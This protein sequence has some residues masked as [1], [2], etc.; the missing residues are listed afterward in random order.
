VQI[1]SFFIDRSTINVKAGS[2]IIL[3]AQG[4][5]GLVLTNS[6]VIRKTDETEPGCGTPIDPQKFPRADIIAVLVTE[7][8]TT[9]VP[10][11][12]AELASEADED[13][14][15]LDL[16]LLHITQTLNIPE[17]GEGPST[18]PPN[19]QDLKR[20][21][22]EHH[23]QIEPLLGPPPEKLES[24]LPILLLGTSEGLEVGD[25]TRVRGYPTDPTLKTLATLMVSEGSIAHLP[26]QQD[27]FVYSRAFIA[28]GISGG[29]IV[30]AA[31]NFLIGVVCGK[32]PPEQDP[33]GRTLTK[34]VPID[35]VKAWLNP[36]ARGIALPPQARIAFRQEDQLQEP[37]VFPQG[38]TIILDASDSSDPNPQG[39]IT[40]YQW[41]VDGQPVVDTASTTTIRFDAPGPH[42]VTLTVTNTA[43]ISSSTTRTV[44]ILPTGAFSTE[45]LQKRLDGA[46]EGAEILIPPGIYLGSLQVTKPLTLKA[47]PGS[48]TLFGDGQLPAIAITDATGA[49][50]DGLTVT[51]GHPGLQIAESSNI[52]IQ[53][54]LIAGN[55]GFGVKITRSSAVTITASKVTNTVPDLRGKLGEGITLEDS[56]QVLI[57]QN[58]I[59]GNLGGGLVSRNSG[60]TLRE[61]IIRANENY[62][63]LIESTPSA[64]EVQ[65]EGNTIE[66]NVGRGLI[67]RGSWV[68]M[69]RD[70]VRATKRQREEFGEGVVVESD[71]N[72]SP[73]PVLSSV[74]IAGNKGAGVLVLE[75]AQVEIRNNSEISRNDDGLVFLDRAGGSLSNSTVCNNVEAGLDVRDSA[76][77]TL[78]NN[79]VSGNWDGLQVRSS[80]TVTLTNSTVSNGWHGLEVWDSAT[81]TL[82]N[83]TVSGNEDDGLRVW[84]SATVTLQD[85]SVS[86]NRWDGLEVWD[87]ATVTLT[88]STVSDN[89]HDGLE[90]GSSATV[91]LENSSISNNW[92]DGFAVSNSATVS[93]TNSTVS[94]NWYDGLSVEDSA[95]VSLTNSSVSNNGDDGLDVWD[96]ATVE[97][98]ESIMSDNKR[99]GIGV[100]SPEAQV[101]STPN[102]MR[103][104]GADLC[105][106]AP[107]S[108]RKPLVPQ[109]PRPHLAVP[110]DY[111]SVQQAIDA[112]APG[113]TIELAPGIYEAGL[114][115]WKPLL[116][117]GAGREQTILQA[118]PERKLVLS[119]IAEVQGVRVEGLQV[120]GSQWAGLLIYGREVTVHDT[121]ISDNE[122]GLS[123]SG[124]AMV[125]LTNFTVSDNEE[126]GLS[127]GGSATVEVRGSTLEGNGT[128][129]DCQ[130]PGPYWW[131]ICSGIEVS[132]Q[133]QTVIIDSRIINNTD[134][135]VAAGLEKCGYEWND[136]VGKVVFEGHNVIEGNNKS[137]NQNGMGNPGNHPWNQPGV[138]DGQVCLP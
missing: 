86:H 75:E 2:G 79:T 94:D 46:P 128:A 112:I 124:S 8:G 27:P 61:N 74:S 136:F 131:N 13:P 127:V 106:W 88:N 96:S 77:V 99:C 50:L 58:V 71:V 19:L 37:P 25:P 97:I 117:R 64:L 20:L 138:P 56:H 126:I 34:A 70:T 68:K 30:E 78:T 26:T 14:T 92:E 87:S 59:E 81:V 66:G 21:L 51:G 91:T 48:V 132:D 41:E 33:Q 107:A 9:P 100:F 72:R 7:W 3:K 119:I 60:L 4:T 85:S 76:T 16:A 134:W 118:L 95:T 65:L 93:L 114:T 101:S 17:Q 47:T 49:R 133:S 122:W 43:R 108:L 1:A 39:Q 15:S 10:R 89:W 69:L 6:H 52:Q 63:V 129:P 84:D 38:A 62:G 36:T 54:S 135:G 137:G 125:T 28:K 121:V 40:N 5:E 123:V 130:Q 73:K 24:R 102:T 42:L 23:G 53:N 82:T 113:G 111:A 120:R 18:R 105:R 110:A 116:L 45:E 35:T 31:S 44:A 98:K 104:N 83:S 11:Y 115:I 80:A 29:A 109:D 103:S 22:E 67:A 57:H 55:L 32:L 90:V 12:L